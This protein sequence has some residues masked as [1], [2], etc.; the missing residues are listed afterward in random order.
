MATAMEIFQK[1]FHALN[2]N[3]YVKNACDALV[4]AF[5]AGPFFA[6]FKVFFLKKFLS[7]FK[8]K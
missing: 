1:Y 8:F 5:E 3:P 7:K 4:T 2:Q 6:T